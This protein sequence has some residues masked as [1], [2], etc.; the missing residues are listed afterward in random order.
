MDSQSPLD[1]W[2]TQLLIAAGVVLAVTSA[3]LLAALDA[4]Q[5]RSTLPPRPLPIVDVAG[6]IAAGEFALVPLPTA[7]PSP[8]M[9]AM[10]AAEGAG[11]GSSAAAVAV[12]PRCGAVPP[13]WEP[14]EAAAGDS[15]ALLALRYGVSLQAI[16][17]ANCLDANRLLPGLTL[18][19]PAEPSASVA[20][21]T[22]GPPLNWIKLRVREGDTLSALAKAHGTTLMRLMQANCL[23]STTLTPGITIY[24]PPRV[25]TAPTD[26]ARAPSLLPPLRSP[27]RHAQPWRRTPRPSAFPDSSATAPAVESPP[28]ATPPLPEPTE[29]APAYPPVSSPSPPGTSPLVPPF[30]TPTPTTPSGGS[31]GPPGS[32]PPP[33]RDTEP[34]EPAPGSTAPPPDSPPSDPPPEETQAP[35]PANPPP[36]DPPPVDPPPPDPPPGNPPPPEPP[37][38]PSYP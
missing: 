29:T 12:L 9:A 6:T 26:P 14:Y 33:T 17:Q 34:T 15:V 4:S 37:P 5:R 28:S 10:P 27:T 20:T 24:V 16:N 18:Y 11:A 13:G 25:L 31:D 38:E 22:C 23:D 32:S 30:T 1:T 3:L 36:A 35:P 21:V 7:T 2:R 8:T 19:L